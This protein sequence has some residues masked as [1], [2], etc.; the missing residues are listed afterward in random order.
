MGSACCLYQQESRPLLYY[1]GDT[2]SIVIR[3]VGIFLPYYKARKPR[4]GYSARPQSMWWTVSATVKIIY[5]GLLVTKI[6]LGLSRGC[7]KKSRNVVVPLSRFLLKKSLKQ[8]WL[9]IICQKKVFLYAPKYCCMRQNIVVCTKILLYAPKY[10]F[11]HQNIVVCTT[12]LLCAPKYCSMHQ[13]IAVCTK[14]LPYAPKYCCMYQ[15]I[16]VCTKIFRYA[17]KYYC[18]H[19]NIAG[20]TKI[21]LYAPKQDKLLQHFINSFSLILIKFSSRIS[22]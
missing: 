14:I 7:L 20:C 22:P 2:L 17:P 8:V 12:I 15:N 6:V 19:Q 13:N 9:S 11:M 21:L 1:A 3:K 18:M 16:A 5:I 4:K 10:C